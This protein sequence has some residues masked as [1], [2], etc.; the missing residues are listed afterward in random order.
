MAHPE[1]ISVE[2]AYA[3]PDRQ[4]SIPL[5]IP[6]GAT[7]EE[8]IRHSGILE[9]FAD[10][11]LAINKVGIFGKLKRLDSKPRDGD[12]IEIYRPLLADPKEARRVRAR[13]SKAARP[14]RLNDPRHIGDRSDPGTR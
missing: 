3:R 4:V 7:I 2:V 8:V 9:Q 14:E 12:R 13:G 10:I 11:D 5:A 1:T 6:P